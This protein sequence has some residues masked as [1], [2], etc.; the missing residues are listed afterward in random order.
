MISNLVHRFVGGNSEIDGFDVVDKLQ[1][2][3][4]LTGSANA[5]ILRY[6]KHSK[7]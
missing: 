1:T 2:R 3:L 5:I 7:C 4:C 6:D